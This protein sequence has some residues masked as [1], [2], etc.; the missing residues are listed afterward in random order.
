MA[1]WRKITGVLR[2]SHP[3]RHD[4]YPC[5]RT[6][7]VMAYEYFANRIPTALQGIEDGQRLYRVHRD[8]DVDASGLQRTR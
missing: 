4:R 2:F 1:G 6:D 8:S 7:N 3:N 5:K